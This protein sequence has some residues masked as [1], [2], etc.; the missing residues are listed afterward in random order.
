MWQREILP[1]K[2]WQKMHKFSSLYTIEEIVIFMIRRGT[3]KTKKNDNIRKRVINIFWKNWE[4]LGLE[5][6]LSD[7]VI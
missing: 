4:S 5:I 2:N 3:Y 7:K 1:L 6:D